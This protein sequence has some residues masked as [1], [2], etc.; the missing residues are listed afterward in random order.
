ML[1]RHPGMLI[2]SCASGGRR[3]DL[4]T[5][6]RAVPLL[7][8]DYTFEPVGEQSHAYG[9]SFW[10][11]YNG[12]GSITAD[13]YLIRSLASPWLTLG[14]DLTAKRADWAP[15][16]KLVAQWKSVV[17]CMLGDYYPLTPYSL[18]NDAWIAWEFNLPEKG[19]GFFQAFRREKCPTA[20]LTVK[21]RGLEPDLSYKVVQLDG[22]ASVTLSGRELMAGFDVKSPTKRT[23]LVFTYEKVSE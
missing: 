2:D 19:R 23:A 16:K 11:P 8:S 20:S 3:N 13:P 1:K 17:P 15:L 9:I 4:E 21:L 12:T 5:L 10:M 22:G 6:R 7:R 14:V 18:A